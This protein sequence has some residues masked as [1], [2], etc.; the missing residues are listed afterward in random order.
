MH[1]I[2]AYIMTRSGRKFEF[3]NPSSN[4]FHLDDIAAA[5][6][7][8]C[9]FGGHMAD[10]WEGI[11]SVAQHSV[12]VYRLLKGFAQHRSK[13]WGLLHDA[14]EAYFSDTVTPLKNLVPELTIMEDRAA[15]VL[16]SA[17]GIPY[18]EEIAKEV[19]WADRATGCAE[20]FH[21][22]GPEQAREMY[23]CE[24]PPFQ[25]TD[26]DPDF[27]LWDFNKAR[28]EYKRAYGE[29][30]TETIEQDRP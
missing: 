18:S 9:R 22:K 13:F 5:L 8:T 25:L 6:A 17:W 26:L 28:T 16:R 4:A 11:Y 29:I 23:G 20:A 27:R 19:H 1:Q 24:Q 30:K 12:Y 15:V 2:N 21:L 7:R 3:E 14:P 10:E